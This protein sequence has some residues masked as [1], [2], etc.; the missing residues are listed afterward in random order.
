MN[1]SGRIRIVFLEEWPS[2]RAFHVLPYLC[3]RFDVTYITTGKRVPD[4]QYKELITF[5]DPKFHLQRAFQFARHTDALYRAGKIDFAYSYATIGYLL[6]ATPYISFLGGSYLED[7]KVS[8]TVLPWHRKWR[9]LSGYI[10]Y[11]IP[12]LVSTKRAKLVLTNSRALRAQICQNYSVREDTVKVIYNGVSE[13]FREVLRE[14]DLGKASS[15]LYIG[16]L[17]PSKGVK[18]LLSAFTKRKHLSMNFYVIGD[19]SE[20]AEIRRLAEKDHRI[21]LARELQTDEIKKIMTGTKYFLFPSL[22]EGCPNVLLEAMAAGHVCIGYDIPAVRE[23]LGDAGIMVSAGRPN[24]ILDEVEKLAGQEQAVRR[25]IEAASKRS[26]CFT[27]DNCA[28]ELEIAL[29]KMNEIVTA[30]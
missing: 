13:S 21:L 25:Y 1:G 27:W 8:A 28:K 10:H 22:Q 11:G 3:E 14:K 20:F 6:T 29:Y 9:I 5:P 4:A 17:H 12:E 30:A 26:S 18:N 7:I 15:A 24:E 2:L 19:G 23:I 16:R